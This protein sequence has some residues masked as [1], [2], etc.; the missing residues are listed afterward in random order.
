[1]YGRLS[2]VWPTSAH[3][4]V[5]TMPSRATLWLHANGVVWSQVAY[6][7]SGEGQFLRDRLVWRA[8]VSSRRKAPAKDLG[9]ER[10]EVDW[11]CL[12]C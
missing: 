9:G 11:R 4:E 10:L 2:L 7:R 1:M 8:G 6:V 3:L 12:G 5:A